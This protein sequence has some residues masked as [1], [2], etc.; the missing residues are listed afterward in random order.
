MCR[1]GCVVLASGEGSR[2]GGEPGSKLTAPLAGRPVLLRTLGA[3]PTDGLDVVVATRWEGVRA[4]CREAGVACVTPEGP[5]KSDSIRAGIASL[6]GC[7]GILFV[8]GDQPLLAESSVR[9][10]A[11]EF[12]RHPSSIVRLAWRGRPAS[13]VIWPADLVPRLAALEGD[14]GGGRLFAEDPSLLARVRLVEAHDV[15]ELV[16][17]DTP[18]ALLSL[19]GALAEGR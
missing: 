18:V 16:D 11:D 9:R 14:T 19:E 10:L 12:L 1:L 4:L 13:P 5:L 2:F 8:T 6:P 7:D 3:L 15:L 17:V